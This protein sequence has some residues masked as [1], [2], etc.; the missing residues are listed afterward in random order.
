MKCP[1]CGFEQP[2]TNVNEGNRFRDA[3]YKRL[4]KY[5]HTK[6]MNPPK[7][8]AYESVR[9][10]IQLRYG[11]QFKAGGSMTK[12]QADKAIAA[13]EEVLPEKEESK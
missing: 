5:G 10:V 9:K 3:V 11:L 8:L 13:L 7:H 6:R 4:E 1:N 12:E 2:Y